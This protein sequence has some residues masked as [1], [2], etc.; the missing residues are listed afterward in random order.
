M[1]PLERCP[2]GAP[3]EYSAC[4]GRYL[5]AD[6]RP[7][8]AEALMRSRYVAYVRGRSD[9]LLRTWHPSTRPAM[10]NLESEPPRW[11]GLQVRRVQSGGAGDRHGIVEF[12]ARYK[13][14]GR[15]HRLHETSR[16]VREEGRWFYVDAVV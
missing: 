10:L 12:V 14:G 11:L 2:C 7:D 13:V 16:F 3:A 15:A 8:T 1:N 9:Y 6:L 5:D 4:C